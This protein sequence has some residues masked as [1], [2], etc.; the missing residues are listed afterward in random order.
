MSDANRSSTPPRNKPKPPMNGVADFR[1]NSKPPAQCEDDNGKNDDG[2]YGKCG[3][4]EG[5]FSE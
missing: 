5:R 2:Q 3:H 4:G 1:P